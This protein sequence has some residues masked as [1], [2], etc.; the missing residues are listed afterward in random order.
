MADNPTLPYTGQVAGDDIGGILFQQMKLNYGGPDEANPVTEDSPF[1]VTQGPLNGL[2][3]SFEDT[4]FTV[5]I[6]LDVNV[7]LGRDARSLTVSCDGPGS[8]TVAVSNDGVSYS[9]EKTMKS[10][11]DFGLD[12]LRVDSVRLTY[13]TDSAYRVVAH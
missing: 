5:T 13:V 7:A 6:T 3:T 10:G 12:G 1:P 8:F 2:C 11:E 4:D 9:P